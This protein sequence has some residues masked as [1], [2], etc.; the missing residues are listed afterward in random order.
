[1]AKFY[2]IIGFGTSV[3]IRPGVYEDEI[4]ERSYYG[5]VLQALRRHQQDQVLPNLKVSNQIS[6][7][8]DAFLNHHFFD[9]RYIY[10]S[11]Q[12]WTVSSVD[13]KRPRLILSLGEV[14]NGPTPTTP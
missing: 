1:M 6:I 14:Y 8:A 5:D 10:W 2:G 7:L 9:I 11:G 12:R 4:V 3:E 13:V